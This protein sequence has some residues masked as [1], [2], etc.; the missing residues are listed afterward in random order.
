MPKTT[1]ISNGN[2]V[3]VFVNLKHP[4]SCNEYTSEEIRQATRVKIRRMENNF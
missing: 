2:L 3:Q 1:R 4:A